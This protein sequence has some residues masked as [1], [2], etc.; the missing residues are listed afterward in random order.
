MIESE[1]SL[2][3]HR[4]CVTSTNC[5]YLDATLAHIIGVAWIMKRDPFKGVDTFGDSRRSMIESECSLQSDRSCVCEQVVH[6]LRVYGLGF[7]V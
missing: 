1:C 6:G 3:S 2:R 5:I 4:S 7:K